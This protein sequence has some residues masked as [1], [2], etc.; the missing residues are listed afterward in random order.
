MALSNTATASGVTARAEFLGGTR[1]AGTSSLPVTCK[2]RPFAAGAPARSPPSLT[3]ARAPGSARHRN[4][5]SGATS[6][7]PRG[8]ASLAR[9]GAFDDYNLAL[10]DTI[11]RPWLIRSGE[12]QGPVSAFRPVTG[13]GPAGIAGEAR[14]IVTEAI[15]ESRHPCRL[16]FG[17]RVD[18]GAVGI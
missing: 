16:I 5:Y 1:S 8:I 4:Q 13:E 6:R 12:R 2:L 15:K 7:H 9:S 14:R 18:I 17:Q 11:Q 10:E 3:V